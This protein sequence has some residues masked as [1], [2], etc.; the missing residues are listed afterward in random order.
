MISR[1]RGDG[2]LMH[3]DLYRQTTAAA[4]DRIHRITIFCRPRSCVLNLLKLRT[5]ILQFLHSALTAECV[6]LTERCSMLIFA[7]LFRYCQVLLLIRVFVAY[8]KQLLSHAERDIILSYSVRLSE[9][10]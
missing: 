1:Q 4:M 9:E 3:T 10:R 7:H 8:S 2:W 6:Q 5:Q